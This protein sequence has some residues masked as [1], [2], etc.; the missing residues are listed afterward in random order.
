MDEL[1]LGTLQSGEFFGE[2]TFSFFTPCYTE[3]SNI[4]QA[5]LRTN[6]GRVGER[7]A[8]LQESSACCPWLAGGGIIA[9]PRRHPTRC[10]TI[11]ECSRGLLRDGF[12]CVGGTRLDG[13]DPL[14]VSVR[15]SV[16]V[17]SCAPVRV[18]V[19]VCVCVCMA[20]VA[21][22]SASASALRA[23]QSRRSDGSQIASSSCGTSCMT[24]RRITNGCS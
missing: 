7:D 18:P 9:L 14:H 21:A 20:V 11:C 24:T 12:E 4:Y 22:A 5:R 13:S 19:C 10:S 1:N 8:F 23:V 17:D 15:S 2:K 3:N 16:C 6:I